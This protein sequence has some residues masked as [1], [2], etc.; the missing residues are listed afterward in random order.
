MGRMVSVIHSPKFGT[1]YPHSPK[2]GTKSEYDMGLTVTKNHSPKF[3][4]CN[5]DSR[6]RGKCPVAGLWC[7]RLLEGPEWWG[8]TGS[9]LLC[10]GAPFETTPERRSQIA[11]GIAHSC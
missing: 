2:F 10:E 9:F 3:G 5:P 4:T 7:Q 8:V 11:C 1:G 6:D